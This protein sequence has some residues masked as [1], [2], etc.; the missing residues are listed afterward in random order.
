VALWF[1]PVLAAVAALAH[2][3]G[4]LRTF[5]SPKQV[6]ADIVAPLPSTEATRIQLIAATPTQREL[7]EHEIASVF[8]PDAPKAFKLLACENAS[9]DPTAVRVNK[10]GS[11]D[12]GLFQ[13]NESWQRTQGKFLLNWHI[14]LLIAK[15][16]YDENGHS[17]RLW[18]CG[19]RLG[20]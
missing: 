15:Q 17:F 11:R 20:L 2:Y 6:E 16:L 18:S 12:M 3:D 4:H 7:I 5:L 19:K 8:G 1:V 14:N 9:L 10:D 13:E